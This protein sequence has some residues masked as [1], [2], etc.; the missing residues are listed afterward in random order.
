M[1]LIDADFLKE[2]VGEYLSVFKK[3]D[4]GTIKGFVD[5]ASTIE[6]KHGEW[7]YHKNDMSCV[8][9]SKWECSMCHERMEHKSNFC[10]NCGSAMTKE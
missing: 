5:H 9:W 7:I 2:W 8:R 3:Y 10:P 6:P 1:R 4:K